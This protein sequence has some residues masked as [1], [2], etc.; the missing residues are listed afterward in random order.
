MS[1][2]AL[3]IEASKIKDNK[4]LP[5]AREDVESYKAY[6]ASDFGGAW[7]DNEIT[8]LRHPSKELLMRWVRFAE[9]FDYS[10]ITFSGHGHHV[11]G[12]KID[13]TRVCIND[14]EEVAVFDLNSGS[15]R[16]LVVADACRKVTQ[17]LV[18][19]YAR[20]FQ[21]SLNEAEK[22]LRPNRR[23]C[24]ELFDSSVTQAERG[25]VYMYSCDLNESAGDVYS[26]SRF[27]VEAGEEWANNARSG[28]L[29][30]SDVFLAAA[31]ATKAKN[32]QQNAK[33]DS[34]RRMTHFPFA[35]LAF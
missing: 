5:G 16:C 12:K 30:C 15:G 31:S 27:L 7:E 3:L 6:L 8:V 19:K 13:E 33:M 4:D 34:G 25:T 28:V 2:F 9:R 24:R 11:I 17:L 20:D 10:F 21:L 26:F 22:S 35:V 32:K 23:R 29:R 1:R 18:E 14:T